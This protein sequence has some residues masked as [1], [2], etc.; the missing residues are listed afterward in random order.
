[1][2]GGV[3]ARVHTVVLA[4]GAGSRFGGGKLLA[5]LDGRPVLQHVLDAVAAA[6][7]TDVVVVLGHDAEAIDQGIVWRTEQRTVNPHPEQGLAGSLRIGAAAQ[8]PGTDAILVVLG[9]QPRVMPDTIRALLDAP[10]DPAY[11]VVVPRYDDDR[12]RNPVFLREGALGLIGLA[13][14]DRG[15]GPILMA[16]ESLVMEVEV[17]GSNPDIDT[18]ED[19]ARLTEAAWAD[20]VHANREQVDRVREVPDGTDFY[21]PVRSMFRADPTRADDPVLRALLAV[22]RPGDTWLDVGAGAGRYALPI[23]R[24]LASSRGSVVALDASASMLDGAREIAA[25][26]GIDNIRC[27]EARW[28]PD[29]LDAPTLSAD[30][31]LIAHVGYDIEAIG[32]FI[33]ALEGASR[34]EL[35]AVLM[36]QMP[37]SAADAFWP[38]VHDQARVTLPAMSE[39]V[40]LLRA[41]GR[42]PVV[43]RVVD[44]RRRF[45]SRDALEAFV[46]RQLWIDPAGPKEV[47]F[48]AA[49][50]AL[51]VAGDDGWTIL[52]RGPVEIGIVR[53][54]AS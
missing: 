16:N 41:R 44:E 30:V 33:S 19:L 52:G 3:T 35:V 12:G 46:R 6:G 53:W 14:G 21:A 20:R 43:E 15:L 39:F 22:A 13:Q 31:V 42:T 7:L 11:P 50:D 48:Q 36:D 29:V 8:A 2:A 23:A 27:V 1:M 45:E 32:P 24:M 49:L 9:D 37:A 47:R 17:A 26:F 5:T 28:P 10:D 51:A 34:R 40:E 4:A 38:P 18:R 25:E 54:T